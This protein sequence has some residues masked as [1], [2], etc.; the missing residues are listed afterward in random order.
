VSIEALLDSVII[1]PIVVN[2]MTII[3]QLLTWISSQAEKAEQNKILHGEDAAEIN[4]LKSLVSRSRSGRETTPQFHAEDCRRQT[5]AVSAVDA[6]ADSTVAAI[7]A[8]C[9]LVHCVSS[10]LSRAYN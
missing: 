1:G 3:I 6:A 8:W 9:P 5:F 2:I 10:S 4:Y 7:L